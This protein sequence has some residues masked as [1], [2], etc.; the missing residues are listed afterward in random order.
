MDRPAFGAAP[1]RV[2]E[3]PAAPRPAP[4][5][6]PAA[7]APAMP[8]AASI[9]L[10]GASLQWENEPAR[11]A[12]REGMS[13]GRAPAVKSRTGG[14]APPQTDP[15]RQ[16]SVSEAPAS[17]PA[18]PAVSTVLPTA[19]TTTFKVEAQ[20]REVKG[21]LPGIDASRYRAAEAPASRFSSDTPTA[22]DEEP[23]E[24]D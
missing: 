3:A 12:A 20:V 15:S 7:P 11:P 17:A 22:W 13:F 9:D 23:K 21:P 16:R 10:S 19:T 8:A 1:T 2:D 6:R 14:V 24:H 18:A 4:A 5:P